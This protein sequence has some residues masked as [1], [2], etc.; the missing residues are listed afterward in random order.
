[1]RGS[2]PYAAIGSADAPARGSSGYRTIYD[3]GED[4]KYEDGRT[5][6]SDLLFVNGKLYGTTQYGGLSGAQ[7]PVGCGTV[8]EAGTS[9]SERVVYRFK[10]GSDGAWPLGRL[11]AAG[12]V[13]YGTASG[14]GSK[15]CAG[16][17]GV[18]FSIDATGKETVLHRF[19]G[20]TDGANPVAGLLRVGTSFYGTTEFGGTTTRLCSHGCGTVFKLSSATESILYR[21]RGG[22][23]GRQPVAPLISYGGRFYGTTQYGGTQTDF[24]ETGCGV[25][26]TIGTAGGEKTLGPFVY[27]KSAPGPA[28]PAASLTVM[29]GLLYGT[30]L[31]GGTLGDGTVFSIA[32][33]SGAVRVIHSFVCC[34]SQNDGAYPVAPL[35]RLGS[36]LYGSTRSGGSSGRGT[37]FAVTASAKESIIYNFLGAPDGAEPEAGLVDVSGDLYGTAA[38]GGTRS[39]GSIFRLPP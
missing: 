11:A 30:T 14:G 28:Y 24:C 18:L 35:L 4:A 37:I 27:A 16:G 39:E 6:A 2:V 33:S 8:Y 1:M 3:F 5:P 10:G 12:G 34:E 31:G 23:D 13:L 17:C 38:G 20:R 29:N 21:F 32:P 7:C 36:T 15:G 26:F 9:G 25:A 22:T 19:T